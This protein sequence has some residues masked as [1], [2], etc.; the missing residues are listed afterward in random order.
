MGNISF[1]QIVILIFIFFFLF[2]DFYRLKK[3][4]DVFVKSINNLIFKKT[5]KK[6]T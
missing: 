4:L 1:K 6:G 5:R 2:G 3:K